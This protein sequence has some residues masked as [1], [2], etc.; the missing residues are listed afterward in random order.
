MSVASASALPAQLSRPPEGLRLDSL[1]FPLA[2]ALD[3]SRLALAFGAVQ[4]RDP[5]P[6]GDH[7]REDVPLHLLDVVDALDPEVEQ[8]DAEVG[9]PLAARSRISRETCSRPFCDDV[10]DHLF[11][12]GLDRNVGPIAVA[13]AHQFDEVVPGDGVARLAVE[14]VVEPRLGAALVAQPLEEPQRI[15]DAPARVGV[16]P[17][18]PL[19][20]RRN[21]VGIAVPFEEPLVE[22]VG[23]LDERQLEVQARVRDRMRRPDRRTG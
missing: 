13:V 5:L 22:V 12:L 10:Q 15:D 3:A 20:L 7:P 23:L 19:V 1:Q 2:L 21:L 14:D 8:L 9:R 11:L 18:E 6:L 16:D 4:L 17:D